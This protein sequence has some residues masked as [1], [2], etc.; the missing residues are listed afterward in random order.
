[1]SV[2]AYSRPPPAV[3]PARVFVKVAFVPGTPVKKPVVSMMVV[4]KPVKATPP[5]P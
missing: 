4:L 3:Q 2:T 1:L 5:V